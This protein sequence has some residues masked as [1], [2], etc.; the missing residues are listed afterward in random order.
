M[1]TS[2]RACTPP[3]RLDAPLT[4]RTML[5]W[6]VM[7]EFS[8]LRLLWGHLAVFRRRPQAARA[9]Q[10]DGDQREGDEQLAQD[11]RVDAAAGDALD[12]AA[13]IAQ[14]LGQGREHQRAE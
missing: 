12:V 6:V 5:S 4:L 1:P 8:S 7:F 9:N 10:H 13:D 14:H 2:D 3:K 11:G